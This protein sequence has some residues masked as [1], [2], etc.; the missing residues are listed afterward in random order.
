M[1]DLH[2]FGRRVSQERRH[3]GVREERDVMAKEVADALEVALSTYLRWEAGEVFPREATLRD[4]AG[5]FGVTVAWLRYGAPPK[6]PEPAN[7]VPTV[8]ETVW[9]DEELREA[10]ENSPEHRNAEDR[11]GTSDRVRRDQTG[12]PSRARRSSSQ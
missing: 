1:D 9:T 6:T 5:Y 8:R 4:L 2:A 12:K 11:T 7:D 10:A 3:K